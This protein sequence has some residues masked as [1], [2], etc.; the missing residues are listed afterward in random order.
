MKSSIVEVVGAV[1]VVAGLALT[2]PALLLSFAGALL[3]AIGYR[4][5]EGR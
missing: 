1:L 3:V 2:A 4:M 5:S